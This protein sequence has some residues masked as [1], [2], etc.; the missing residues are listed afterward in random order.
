MHEALI[1]CK[2]VTLGCCAV[3]YVNVSIFS[4]NFVRD[5]IYSSVT[6]L[7]ARY[8]S[9]ANFGGSEFKLL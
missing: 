6:D 1:C 9:A 4:Y 3:S 2:N 5:D 7:V 8:N